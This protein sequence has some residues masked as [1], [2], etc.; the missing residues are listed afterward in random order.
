MLISNQGTLVRTAADEVSQLGRN[1]QGVRIIRTKPGEK[2]VRVERIADTQAEAADAAGAGDA[3]GETP[4]PGAAPTRRRMAVETAGSPH[5]P[6]ME[7]LRR[8]RGAARGRAR[9]RRRRKC[10]T[11]TARACPSWR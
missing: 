7:L 5:E 3:T 1:T 2:L 6:A 11:G 10:S 4:A 9:A 8:P